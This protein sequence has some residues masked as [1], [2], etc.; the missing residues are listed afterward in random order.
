[1]NHAPPKIRHFAERL[2]AHAV[3]GN[4][5]KKIEFP[6]ALPVVSKMR[7][8]LAT[9][10]G[11]GGF[12]TLVARALARAGTEVPWLLEIRVK[13]DGSLDGFDDL[14]GRVDP[15]EITRGSVVL[16]ASMLGLLVAFIGE[17]LTLRL[18]RDIW[19]KFPDSDH[20]TQ[21]DKNEK[22]N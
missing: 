6:T 10:M 2:M 16:V 20:F 3:Q 22:T 13:T 1:M 8:H 19:P 15:A 12:D 4:R 5:S 9:L 14:E 7:P 18:M 11:T 17:I 21:G